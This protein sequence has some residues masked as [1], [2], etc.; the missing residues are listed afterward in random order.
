[1]RGDLGVV[2]E[3][4]FEFARGTAQ[5]PFEFR[6]S[7]HRKANLVLSYARLFREN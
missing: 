1:V 2:R 5:W 6:L 4:R 3:T 7:R